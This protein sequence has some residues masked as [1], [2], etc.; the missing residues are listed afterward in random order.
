MKFTVEIYQ[1]YYP[2]WPLIEAEKDWYAVG[3]YKY[4]TDKVDEFFNRWNGKPL[5]YDHAFGNQCVD[6]MRAFVSEVHGLPP[7]TAIP[8]TGE[9]AK[10]FDNFKDNQYF[11]KILNEKTNIPVRGDIIF[12][13]YYP[14]LYSSVGHVAIVD[15]ADLYIVRSF[16]QN[17]PT[18]SYCHFQQHGSSKWFHGYRGCK[19]WLRRK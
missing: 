12:W 19:G 4:G 15:K 18:K 13:G 17:W 9:A 11:T 5:D 8:Y 2:G 10:I 7:Y 3:Q 6:V 16:D 14:F 1:K